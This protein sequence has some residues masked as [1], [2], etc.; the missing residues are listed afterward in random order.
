MCEYLSWRDIF[1][2]MIR[3]LLQKNLWTSAGQNLFESPARNTRENGYRGAM[4][5][6]WGFKGGLCHLPTLFYMSL[7]Q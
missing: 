3:F 1:L 5:F 6:E 7:G 4:V 2:G